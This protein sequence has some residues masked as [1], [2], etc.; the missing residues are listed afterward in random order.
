MTDHEFK[1][2]PR[3]TTDKDLLQSVRREMLAAW[4]P[5]DSGPL[6]LCEASV[7]NADGSD[8][9]CGRDVFGHSW[10]DGGEHEPLL[11]MACAEHSNEGG[12]WMAG[13]YWYASDLLTEIERLTA[14]RDRVRGLAARL[15]SQLAQ[16]QELADWHETKAMEAR[17]YRTELHADWRDLRA[18]ILDQAAQFHEGATR[19]LRAVLA[20]P[21]DEDDDDQAPDLVQDYLDRLKRMDPSP[22]LAGQIAE[23]EAAHHAKNGGE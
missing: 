16:V 11:S 14:E 6:G 7:T 17:T 9:P 23:L 13:L 21:V 5:R 15:E 3:T 8:R 10:Y 18:A 19:R 20:S 2:P 12:K 1:A 4:A 22:T